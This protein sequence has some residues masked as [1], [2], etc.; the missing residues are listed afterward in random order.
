M[1]GWGEL[2]SKKGFLWGYK[3]FGHIC[4][5]CSIWEA[6][7]QIVSREQGSPDRIFILEI[8]IRSGQRIFDL[9]ILIRSE[10]QL[11][12][13]EILIRSA[14]RI[15]DHEI[16]IRSADRIFDHEI[17][18]RSADRIFDPDIFIWSGYRILS[19][20]IYGSNIWSRDW[21]QFVWYFLFNFK[22]QTN[23]PFGLR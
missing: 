15:F 6:N 20:E 11:F 5:R 9:E 17:V 2:F 16:V 1:A 22:D 23:V 8:L 18:I 12:D 10:D 4:E 13:L 19:F 3:I 14:E 21:T 7:D